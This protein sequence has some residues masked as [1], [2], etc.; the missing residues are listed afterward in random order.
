MKHATTK[1]KNVLKLNCDEERTGSGPPVYTC[2]DNNGK[3]QT[4]TPGPEWQLVELRPACL[5]N[6][7]TDTVDT[8]C[9]GIAKPELWNQK[10]RNNLQKK[11]TTNGG[12]Y[13]KKQIIQ[14]ATFSGRCIITA[15]Q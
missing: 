2:Y 7:T 15:C 3:E 9:A 11:N 8:A 6:T 10:T 12:S 4:I 14:P 1:T 13:E 5:L